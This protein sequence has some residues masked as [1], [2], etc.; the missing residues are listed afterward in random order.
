MSSSPF[1]PQTT[2]NETSSSIEKPRAPVVLSF[3]E[4]EVD[5]VPLPLLKKSDQSMLLAPPPPRPPLSSSSSSSSSR[6][7]DL[8]SP[9]TVPPF[10]SPSMTSQVIVAEELCGLDSAVRFMKW[11]RAPT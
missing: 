5:F 7:S 10:G 2:S 6:I 11:P 1:T 9:V 3:H 4:M 8:S